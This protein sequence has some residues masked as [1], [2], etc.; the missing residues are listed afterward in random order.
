[1][2]L[3]GKRLSRSSKRRRASK[4]RLKPA[5]L[6]T[7]P[8]CQATIQPHRACPSCGTYRGRSTASPLARVAKK[9]AAKP[10][11]KAKAKKA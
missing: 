3:P 7:C 6:T 9:P 11:A 8:S 1:M 2:G 5:S 10:K 4:V